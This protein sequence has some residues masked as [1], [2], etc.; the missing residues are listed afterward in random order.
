MKAQ[1]VLLVFIMTLTTFVSRASAQTDVR[2]HRVLFGAIWNE[3]VLTAVST[4]SAELAVTAALDVLASARPIAESA[5]PRQIS[6]TF[7]NNQWKYDL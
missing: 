7:D 1:N 6:Q 4:A 3:S 2:P 5:V